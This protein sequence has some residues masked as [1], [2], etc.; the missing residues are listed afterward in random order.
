VSFRG[1]D[2]LDVARFLGDQD[3]GEPF[4]RSSISRAYY[5]AFHASVEFCHA[6]GSSVPT[7]NPHLE[8]RR[9]L[10]RHGQGDTA[11]ELRTLHGWRKNADYDVPFPLSNMPRIRT[12][13]IDLAQSIVE[14]LT[15]LST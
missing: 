12:M 1:A 4:D 14:R 6:N 13:A 10:E 9:C 7:M 8:V 3:A 5:A 11:I 15:R 2:F